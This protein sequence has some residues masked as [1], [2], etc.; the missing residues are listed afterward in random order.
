VTDGDRTL[1]LPLLIRAIPGGGLDASSPY[2]YPGPIGKGTDDAAFVRVALAAGLQALRDAGLVSVFVRLH[3]LLNP[4]PPEGIGVLVHHGETVSIDLTLP[5]DAIWAQMRLNHRRDIV[6]ATK[7]GFVARVDED[8]THFETFKCLYRQTMERRSASPF[9]F[10]PDEYFRDLRAALGRSLRL[11]VVEKA[12]VVAAAGLFVETDGIVEYHLSGSDGRL[13]SVQPTKL[14]IHFAGGWAR[15]RGNSVLHLGGGVGGIADSLLQFKGGFSPRRHPFVTLRIVVD[16]QEYE[17][18][19]AAR[20]PEIDPL[21]R[22]GF[23]PLYRL[24]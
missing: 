23:F 15:E 4:V 17:R 19:V 22:S 9:Y 24:A 12:G 8:W 10:F 2:G 5:T 1:L 16:E 14:L 20:H 7:L 3:P 18:L 11:C 13:Q 6:R 21:R